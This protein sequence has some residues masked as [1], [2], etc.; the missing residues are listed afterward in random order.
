MKRIAALIR[1]HVMND[2]VV[3]LYRQ[4]VEFS[5]INTDVFLYCDFSMGD[6]PTP[7]GIK[8]ESHTT[9]DAAR[10]DLLPFPPKRVLW[11]N[12]DYPFY[13]FHDAKP[14][15]DLYVMIE[16][17]VFFTNT[18]LQQ[19]FRHISLVEAD[20]YGV[21]VRPARAGWKWAEAAKA[22]RDHVYSSFF[23]IVGLSKLAIQ[24]LLQSRQVQAKKYLGGNIKTW[25]HC[26]A[27]VPT[28]IYALGLSA[29]NLNDCLNIRPEKFSTARHTLVCSDLLELD[30][31]SSE[32]YHPAI[33]HQEFLKTLI[34]QARAEPLNSFLLQN[35]NYLKQVIQLETTKTKEILSSL[36]DPEDFLRVE[37]LI[38]SVGD[39]DA[40]Y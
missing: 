2:L 10:F 20:Y 24:K 23:P 29:N 34:G 9:K 16:Y 31:I 11:Y 18:A 21:Y 39:N 33:P 32:F 19:F 3:Q 22:H 26:E 13:F 4:M 38:V 7:E 1:T 12:G 14:D 8:F 15:Y 5:P 25:I 6:L 35:P 28:E 40:I 17:D 36:L 37:E 27:F 30:S